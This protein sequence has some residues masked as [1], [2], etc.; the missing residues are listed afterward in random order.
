MVNLASC[1]RH[2]P[3]VQLPVWVCIT[4]RFLFIT[5]LKDMEQEVNL[6]EQSYL[7]IASVTVWSLLFPINQNNG[8]GFNKSWPQSLLIVRQS[9]RNQAL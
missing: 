8:Q 7:A 1:G 9:S 4:A 5:Q 2:S 6:C 3:N